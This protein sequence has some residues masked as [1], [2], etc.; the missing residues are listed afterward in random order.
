MSLFLDC[1][2]GISGDM[3]TASLLDL[4]V[5]WT[6][7]E[8]ELSKIDLDFEVSKKQ[9]YRTGVKS[10]KFDVFSGGQKKHRFLSDILSLIEYS[11]LSA[12][13]KKN[14][15]RIFYELG[16]AESSAHNCLLEEVFFHEIGAVD[17]I[18]DVVSA[19]VLLDKLKVKGFFINPVSVGTGSL[20]IEG[21]K[22][23]SL[24]APATKLLLKD[25]QV[26]HTN[27]PFELT[28][29]TGASLVKVFCMGYY[30]IPPT[31]SWGFGAGLR[32]LENP[33]VLGALFKT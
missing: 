18:V 8:S 12:D 32:D 5:S 13:V 10:T 11:S 17:S 7:L 23:F 16:L 25:F 2:S 29:P 24:P 3:F 1:S 14:A 19:C 4:G 28:T 27:I 21:H 6:Y 15:S 30:D 26:N 22:S 9:V 20:K 33:N 31:G